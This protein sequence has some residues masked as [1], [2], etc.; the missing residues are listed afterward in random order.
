MF[1]PYHNKKLTHKTTKEQHNNF[2]NNRRMSDLYIEVVEAYRVDTVV[3][4]RS[5]RQATPSHRTRTIGSKL[6]TTIRCLP[7]F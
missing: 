7:H 1:S 3:R 2:C 4:E 5:C 6:G